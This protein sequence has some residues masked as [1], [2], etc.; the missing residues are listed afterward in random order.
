MAPSPP[1]AFDPLRA[2]P[3]PPRPAATHAEDEAA[4]AAERPSKT[5]LKKDM[6]ELQRL[7]V[8]LAALSDDRLDAL[9]LPEALRDAL[10]EFQ[11]TRSHEG[12][13]RQTQYIGKL[14]RRA[15]IEPIREAVAAAQL[16]GARGALALHR[17]EAWRDELLADDAALERWA[18]QHPQGDLQQLRS[19]IRA[20]RKDAAADAAPGVALRK[21]RAFRELF[22]FIK[23]QQDDDE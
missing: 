8:A 15:E 21:G 5:Q 23:Q 7:G 19:L 20:A 17:A 6:H 10:H 3:M 14:M 4:P 2:P 1:L 12:R 16:G 9:A 22:Q 11:R 13:R 18:A